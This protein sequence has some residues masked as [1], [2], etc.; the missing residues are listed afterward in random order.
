M[1]NK[2]KA[3]HI[4]L[5][6]LL[7]NLIIATSRSQAQVIPDGTL[8]ENSS[9][10]AQGSITFIEGGTKLG[11][12]LF[13]SFQYFSIDI[14]KTAY[15]N[16]SLDVQNIIGRVTGNFVS[17]I[18]GLIRNN[19]LANLLLI[20]PNGIIFGA[21]ASL[22]IGGSFIATTAN[23]LKFS[24]GTLFGA[25]VNHN[26]INSLLTIST[27]VGLV[28][29]GNSGDIIVKNSGHNINRIVNRNFDFINP[30]DSSRFSGLKVNPGHSIALIGGNI[31]LDGGILSGKNVQIEIGSIQN[32][33]ISFQQNENNFSFD[34]N[35]ANN[36][37]EITLT[38]NSLLF[39][40]STKG[41]GNTI[42]IQGEK[43]KIL[44]GSLIF[45]QN[46]GFKTGSVNINAQNLDIQGAS[47]LALSAIYTS[48]FGFTAGENIEIAAQQINIQGGQI[49]TTTFT[50]ASSG[51]IQINSDFSKILG[52]IPSYANPDGFG[53]INTFSYS[54]GKGGDIIANISNISI[55]LDGIINTSS[56]SSGRAGDI[57]INANNLVLKDGG[58]SLGSSTF[59]NGEGGNVF[60]K[61]Q[62]VDISGQSSSLRSSSINSLT[63]GSGNAG[64]VE[65]ETSQLV[66]SDGGGITSS[67][68][69]AGNAGNI[70]I[71]STDSI[72]ILG[73]SSNLK[74][75][76]FIESSTF[77]L[78]DENLKALFY[79]QP[80]SL[81]GQAGNIF[82]D[83]GTLNIVNSGLVSV[84][85]EGLNNA[86]SI[87][88]TANKINII[89]QGEINATTA[90]G[91]G[92]NITLTS[93]MVLL[94]NGIISAT[95][96]QQGS[97]GNGGNIRI[98]A[99]VITGFNNSQITANA[100]EGRGGNITINTQGL[101]FSEDSQFTASSQRGI[102]GVIDINASITQPEIVKAQPELSIP[103][104]EIASVCQ[105][106]TNSNV[107]PNQFMITGSSGIPQGLN[108]I[109]VSNV[110]WQDNSIANERTNSESLKSSLPQEATKITP[111]QGWQF[112]KD[113][114]VT[115]IEAPNTTSAEVSLSSDPCS[116]EPSASEL[117]V[118][119][120]IKG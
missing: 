1:N 119:S 80:L 15:F 71:N 75:P 13:H 87:E 96:G 107:T 31:L 51:L 77:P 42:N 43:A 49:A 26:Q 17:N 46:H 69:S 34:Y 59:R 117:K 113:G 108:N 95:A 29:T 89:N 10:K 93:K 101:F 112:N 56:L 102:N 116:L 85:N 84:R 109:P 104:S 100:F 12:N 41:S 97:S 92:G 86:G 61:S 106:R 19:G 58:A 20:N 9:V 111:A 36:F 81:I 99:D 18:D 83:T 32:G 28:F 57:L 45:A 39:V 62:Y 44:G 55:G 88:V 65:L 14:G 16:N 110:N 64:N 73:I 118:N 25:G 11:G 79:R 4:V 70:K 90:I 76:S 50:N 67:T 8:L 6:I 3:F 37:N 47:K 78:I 63:F 105:A 94:N 120:H 5:P 72:N 98:N 66:I 35:Q 48:N 27:P 22:N 40:N 30:I 7:V 103:H 21:N 52:D 24:D 91:Q 82:L 68:L 74:S 114:T 23:N 33:Y 53:G 38:N 60:I 2:L 54:S 115:L